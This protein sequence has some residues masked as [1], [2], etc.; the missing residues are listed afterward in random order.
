MSLQI[1]VSKVGA[2]LAVPQTQRNNFIHLSRLF[3]PYYLVN[4]ENIAIKS[5]IGVFLVNLKKYKES[6]FHLM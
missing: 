2:W 3:N 4:P 6:T 5:T 1:P